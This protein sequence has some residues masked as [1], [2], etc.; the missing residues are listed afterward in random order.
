MST[1]AKIF[2][3]FIESIE[4]NSTRET[5]IDII[6]ELL[7][8]D[9]SNNRLANNSQFKFYPK[10]LEAKSSSLY[11]DILAQNLSQRIYKSSAHLIVFS[12]IFNLD[13]NCKKL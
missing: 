12:P 11:S 4:V 6:K 9:I 10:L 13:E 5:F 8:Y 1:I 7:H 3:E 2:L